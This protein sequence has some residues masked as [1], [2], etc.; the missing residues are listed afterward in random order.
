MSRR[1]PAAKRRKP[2]VAKSPRRVTVDYDRAIRLVATVEFHLV[3]ALAGL[4]TPEDA[5]W[6]TPI[7]R[8]HNQ[9]VRLLVNPEA[10]Q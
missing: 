1:K 6:L 8:A 10:G 2:A 4:S 5:R 3:T 9:L 7:A